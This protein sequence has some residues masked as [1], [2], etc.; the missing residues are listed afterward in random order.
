M[1]TTCMAI[2]P[3]SSAEFSDAIHNDLIQQSTRFQILD[4]NRKILF[5]ESG[6]RDWADPEMVSRMKK[7]L[8]LAG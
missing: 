8:G 4:Q 1:I 3:G 6:G 5:V 2:H 7:W